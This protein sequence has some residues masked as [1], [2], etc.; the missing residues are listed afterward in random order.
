MADLKNKEVEDPVEVHKVSTEN[1]KAQEI[2][3]ANEIEHRLTLLQAIKLYPKAI[4]WSMYFSLGVIMLCKAN[5]F[6]AKFVA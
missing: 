3:E 6:R 5:R 1:E 2:R 4:G